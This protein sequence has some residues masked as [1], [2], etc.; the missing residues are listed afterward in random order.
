M[1]TFKQRYEELLTQYLAAG[2][3]LRNAMHHAVMQI[4][5]QLPSPKGEGLLGLSLVHS[6]VSTRGL[7]ASMLCEVK[8]NGDYPTWS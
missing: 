2:E 1:K 7:V 4:A 6:S 8:R 3:L 5:G